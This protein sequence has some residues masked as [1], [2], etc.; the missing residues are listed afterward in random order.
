MISSF[1]FAESSP[2]APGTV[3]S[4]KPV[5]NS[6]LTGVAWPLDDLGAWTAYVDCPANS[7]GGTLTVVLQT[8]PDGVTFYDAASTP[9]TANGAGATT[10]AI[11]I[12][13]AS[14]GAILAVGK[15]TTPA[16]AA[17]KIAGGGM[18]ERCRLAITAGSGAS[19][20]ITVTVRLVAQRRRASEYGR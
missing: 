2:S 12:S 19:S 16:I 1:T 7:T 14:P 11:P 13:L 9:A 20:S 3:I 8:S 17:G 15:G 6:T 5:A 18:T 10:Y 4:S